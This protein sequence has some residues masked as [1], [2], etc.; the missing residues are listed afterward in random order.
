M[1]DGGLSF[2]AATEGYEE[3]PQATWPSG[4]VGHGDIFFNPDRPRPS[5][6]MKFVWRRHGD[7]G[8]RWDEPISIR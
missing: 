5:F 8:M 4:H 6:A 3:D 1:T 7:T 2:G